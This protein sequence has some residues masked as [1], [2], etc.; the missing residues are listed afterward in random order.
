V[1]IAP[2]G[3]ALRVSSGDGDLARGELEDCLGRAAAGWKFPAAGAEYV[4]DVPITVLRG[5][6]AR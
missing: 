6:S 4:V 3:R 1:A 2:D 5:G